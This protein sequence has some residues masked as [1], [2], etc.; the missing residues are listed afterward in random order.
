MFKKVQL[1]VRLITMISA[2]NHNTSEN[3][4]AAWKSMIAGIYM[5]PSNHTGS[6]VPTKKKFS[7][8]VFSNCVG[9]K[10]INSHY[11]LLLAGKKKKNPFFFS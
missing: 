10:H 6:F 1:A 9:E 8:T 5:S 4:S 3:V 2:A 7:T 11:Y